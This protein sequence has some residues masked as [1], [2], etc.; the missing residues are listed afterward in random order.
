MDGPQAERW[1]LSPEDR[2]CKV[3]TTAEARRAESYM[4][5]RETGYR[6][7]V[8]QVKETVLTTPAQKGSSGLRNGGAP[9]HP[10]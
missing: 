2:L 8:L 3:K 6:V 1:G 5:K 4:G 7:L 10:G 9:P